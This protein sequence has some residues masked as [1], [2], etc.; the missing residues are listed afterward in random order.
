M[1]AAR[2]GAIPLLRSGRDLRPAARLLAT[3]YARQVPVR[4][5]RAPLSEGFLAL[6]AAAHA[7]KAEQPCAC[8]RQS[9]SPRPRRASVHPLQTANA[10]L[11]DMA[12]RSSGARAAL[13]SSRRT[14]RG[15]GA[16]VQPGGRRR[17]ENC[18]AI[19]SR[20]SSRI[21]SAATGESIRAS[22]KSGI[23]FPTGPGRPT[24]SKW[25]ISAWSSFPGPSE[26]R[27]GRK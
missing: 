24:T 20:R 9:A 6:A 2:P 27:A 18:S 15:E 16:Q 25:A 5:R 11:D 4:P 19:R 23:P 10:G 17:E 26:R 8:R 7:R 3:E 22:R 21:S 13:P 1:D 12:G 14:R